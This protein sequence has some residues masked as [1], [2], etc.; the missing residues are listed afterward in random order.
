MNLSKFFPKLPFFKSARYNQRQKKAQILDLIEN[1]APKDNF[2]HWLLNN[3]FKVSVS[4]QDAWPTIKTEIVNSGGVPYQQLK[5]YFATLQDGAIL[6]ETLQEVRKTTEQAE[7]TAKELSDLNSLKK[8]S[9]MIGGI[10][11]F[12]GLIKLGL[13]SLLL[14]GNLDFLVS[15]QASDHLFLALNIYLAAVGSFEVMGGIFLVT[16]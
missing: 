12:L 9:I 3:E 6:E 16:L 8:F 10:L 1:K 4:E 11:T 14:F 7:A 13:I 15:L 5:T 2:V